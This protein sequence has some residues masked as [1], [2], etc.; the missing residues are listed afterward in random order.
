MR[1]AGVSDWVSATEQQ[2]WRLAGH[3][4]RRDDGRWSTAILDWLPEGGN[5]GAGR[6]VKRWEEDIGKV[7]RQRGVE[8]TQAWRI[9]AACR[10]VWQ[11]HEEAFTG[12]RRQQSS[13]RK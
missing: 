6:P 2:I 4:S 9:A 13:W 1:K 3:I 10:E 5:R 7:F 8:E 11:D 12:T